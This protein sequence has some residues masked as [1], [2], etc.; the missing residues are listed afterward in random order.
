MLGN[1]DVAPPQPS[2]ERGPAGG[3]VIERAARRLDW[4]FAFG[5]RHDGPRINQQSLIAAVRDRRL[6]FGSASSTRLLWVS[7]ICLAF[8]L[9]AAAGTSVFL[10]S[11]SDGERAAAEDAP[12]REPPAKPSENPSLIGGLAMMPPAVDARQGARLATPRPALGASEA[13]AMLAHPAAP[14]VEPSNDLAPRPGTPR[15]TVTSTALSASRPTSEPTLSAVEIAA[16]LARA[17]WFFGTGDVSSA[18]LLFERAVDA[19]DARGALRLAETFDPGFLKDAHLGNARADPDAAMFWY[20][21]AR[22]MGA[23]EATGRLRRLE[24]SHTK[25]LQ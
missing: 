22:D 19:G 21:R 5:M 1:S 8:L 11:Y 10:R 13:E 18:R 16:V 23:A 9:I 17:D 20:R 4:T 14:S 12:V 25:S 15:P 6:R 24:V 2:A 3:S 7:V